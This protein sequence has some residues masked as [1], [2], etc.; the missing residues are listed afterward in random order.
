VTDA[1]RSVVTTARGD[2]TVS[3]TTRGVVLTLFSISNLFLGSTIGHVIT[4]GRASENGGVPMFVMFILWL[5]TIL[6]I[7]G[8][9]YDEGRE[10]K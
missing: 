10:S 3:K 7:C 6:I 5:L 9:M 2:D 4:S 8:E 1:T